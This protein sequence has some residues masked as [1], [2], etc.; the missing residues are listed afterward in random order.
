MKTKQKTKKQKVRTY[1]AYLLG[2]AIITVV[3]AEV[4]FA[5]Y[6]TS[7]DWHDGFAVLDLSS[8]VSQTVS[9][10]KVA[11]APAGFALESINGF[12]E[13]SA[14]AMTQVLD[15]SASSD[16]SS[17]MDLVYGVNDFYQM[18]TN[19]MANVL[20]LSDYLPSASQQPRVAGAS[21]IR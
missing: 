2:L 6:A 14:V 1:E 3:A 19:E 21:V 10:M 15:M 7:S 17:P 9:D 5:N 4:G 13:Q 18:A 20:D 16:Q 12:Y 8:S 11:F